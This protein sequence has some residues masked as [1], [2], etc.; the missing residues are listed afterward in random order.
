[1]E[2]YR[3]VGT[4]TLLLVD[5]NLRVINGWYFL[6][7]DSDGILFIPDTKYKLSFITH[8]YY[9]GN[10]NSTLQEVEEWLEDKGRYIGG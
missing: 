8:T 1:M 5:K 7:K 3:I 4:K 9:N 2:V 10:Y 6:K